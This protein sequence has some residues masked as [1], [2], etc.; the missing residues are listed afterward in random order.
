MQ[1]F[2]FIFLARSWA[3]DREQL[4]SHLSI[5]GEQAEREDN[6]LT[7]ILYPEGTLVSPDTRPISKKFA[8]KMGIPDMTNILLPRSTGL[9]YSLRSLAPRIPSLHLIDLTI[10]YPGIP[11][12]KYGQSYYSLRSIFFDRVPPPVIHVHLRVFNVAQ[13]VPIGEVSTFNPAVVPKGPPNGHA[14]EID[15]SEE[16]KEK[17]DLWL[18]ELWRDKDQLITK[19][20]ETG[21]FTAE[22]P[23]AI[24]KV[25]IP[26]ELRRKREIMDGFCFFIPALVGCLWAKL[27]HGS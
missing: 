22:K 26:L 16:E 13:D 17:F 7:L 4:A 21:S 20:L 5:L 8:D 14:T 23:D 19:F 2:K 12:L 1:F 3:S 25:E 9:H 27:R 11:P 10:V 24:T 6:P 15:F 18:R